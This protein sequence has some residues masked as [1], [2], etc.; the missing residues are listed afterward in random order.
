[1]DTIR[2]IG[3]GP[4]APDGSFDSLSGEAKATA[5]P[6]ADEDDA[7]MIDHG[8]GLAFADTHHEAPAVVVDPSPVVYSESGEF[9][10]DTTWDTPTGPITATVAPIADRIAEAV[11]LDSPLSD[12]EIA[13]ETTALYRTEIAQL[14][15]LCGNLKILQTKLEN[16]WSNMSAEDMAAADTQV[17]NE[18]FALQAQ[19]N[20][21]MCIVIPDILSS[22]EKAGVVTFEFNPQSQ[23]TASK[24]ISVQIGN[25]ESIF[26]A[27]RSKDR[28][29]EYVI[30]RPQKNPDD[31]SRDSVYLYSGDQSGELLFASYRQTSGAPEDVRHL[32]G[33]HNPDATNEANL[34]KMAL[35]VRHIAEALI[36]KLETARDEKR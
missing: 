21:L 36:E 34:S 23:T 2:P 14:R 30:K 1:M 28:G 6:T 10:I 13:Q 33:P 22:L 24:P 20:T 11:F 25:V 9:A 26:T 4:D 19:I 3:Q 17:T 5:R 12:V 18:R 35:C 31:T 15:Q 16:E 7:T 29:N 32:V 27:S 8:L